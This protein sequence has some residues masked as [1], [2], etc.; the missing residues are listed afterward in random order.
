MTGK[1]EMGSN[2]KPLKKAGIFA[3]L[4]R[5]LNQRK[6]MIHLCKIEAESYIPEPDRNPPY[7]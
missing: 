4:K 5:M 3:I 1:K 7:S 2:G 6:V